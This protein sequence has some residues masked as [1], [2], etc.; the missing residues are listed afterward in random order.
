[1]SEEQPQDQAPAPQ[2]ASPAPAS[3]SVTENQ[4][5]MFTHL[6][7]LA[8][9]IIPYGNLVGPLIL[10]VLKKDELPEVDRHGKEA[11]NCQ[12]SA[13]IYMTV[14]GAIGTFLLAILIGIPILLLVGVVWLVFV[15]ILPIIAGLKA[16]EGEFY[17]YPMTIRFLK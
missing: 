6:A 8:G 11:V 3:Q 15:I 2:A 5:A 1:M 9:L 10:W 16:K 12:I 17:R 14:G 7:A 13:S 4:W